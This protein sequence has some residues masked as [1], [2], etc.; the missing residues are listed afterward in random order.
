MKAENLEKKN[1]RH[2][3]SVQ[4]AAQVSSHY[5]ELWLKGSVIASHNSGRTRWC[6]FTSHL[7]PPVFICWILC[8]AVGCA[9]LSIDFQVPSCCCRF[10]CWGCL[11]HN[12][13]FSGNQAEPWK[14]MYWS[15]VMEG[16]HVVIWPAS[17]SHPDIQHKS[18][19]E[20][21]YYELSAWADPAQ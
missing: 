17:G 2:R 10:W 14:T 6:L 8:L 4:A 19:E 15:D 21:Y 18:R 7:F 3:M 20:N 13:C 16:V 1:R 9:W 12:H 11:S 5:W